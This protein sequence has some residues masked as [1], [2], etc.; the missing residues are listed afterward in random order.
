MKLL[1]I[2]NLLFQTDEEH[3]LIYCDM[4]YENTDFSW[5][6]KYKTFLKENGIFIVQTDWHTVSEIDSFI[7]MLGLTVVNH[8][9]QKCEWGNHPRNR[10]HQCYDDI[11]IY[12]NGT[13]WNFF[14]DKIQ[15]PKATANT[16][17]NPSGRMTKTA[18]AWIDDVVLTTS[19]NERVKKSDGHLA[20]WQKPLKLYDRIITPFVRKADKILD[21]FMGVGSLG[22]WCKMNE[23]DYTGIELDSEIF[24]L[25][26]ENI[27]V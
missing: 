19:S 17:L 1:N 4:I 5:A 25:A 22:K 7:K 23:M 24:E 14:S 2:D 21:P 26:K 11:L 10:F 13:N 15:V 20:R 8:L 12:C 27:G 18:T 16:K 6:F 3:D 9:V